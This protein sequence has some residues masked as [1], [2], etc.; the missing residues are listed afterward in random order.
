MSEEK[1][2]TCTVSTSVGSITAT[3]PKTLTDILFGSEGN[4]NCRET[5][6]DLFDHLEENESEVY[7]LTFEKRFTQKELDEMP[8]SDGDIH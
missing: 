1:V 8:E 6:K 7:T 3:D 4:I 2:I 5:I